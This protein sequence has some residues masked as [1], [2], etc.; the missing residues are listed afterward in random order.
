MLQSSKD[1][2]RKTA[3]KLLQF[4]MENFKQTKNFESIG[5]TC[6]YLFH[7]F[8][9]YADSLK[10]LSLP[11]ALNIFIHMCGMSYQ[12]INLF[13]LTMSLYNLSISGDPVNKFFSVCW[14]YRNV[15]G[16]SEI[17]HFSHHTMASFIDLKRWCQWLNGTYGKITWSHTE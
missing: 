3:T 13:W 5:Q 7:Y 11:S 16:I 10:G 8:F 17:T 9:P 6:N 4:K 2:E 14:V 12:K 15:G 1:H